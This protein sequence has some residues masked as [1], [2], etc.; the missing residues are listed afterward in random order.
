MKITSKAQFFEKWMAGEL[1]NRTRLWKDPF[2]A[3]EEARK[4][5]I[6]EIGFREIRPA[7]TVGAGKWEKVPREEVL[8][9][10]LKWR[11]EGRKFLMD[12][13]VPADRTTLIGEVCRTYKGLEG[14]LAVECKMPMRPAMAAGKLT[15][16][17]PLDT[18]FL[19]RKYMDPS[20]QED[21]WLLLDTYPDAA[22]EFACF[23]VDVGI[24]PHRNTMMWEVR[25]Y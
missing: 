9:A 7:G 4:F 19:I 11:E 14:Y 16:R 2:L 20:S 23:S 5:G 10:A 25:D 1:G 24:Y 21:L 3:L 22:V 15:P 12:D 13:G 18:L 17:S 6:K 8:C